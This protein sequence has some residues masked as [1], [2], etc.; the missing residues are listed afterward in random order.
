MNARIL[1]RVLA[2]F[3]FTLATVGII[4]VPTT[5]LEDPTRSN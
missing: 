1:W 3:A 2:V 5:P 4:S